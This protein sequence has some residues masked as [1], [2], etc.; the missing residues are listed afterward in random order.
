MSIAPDKLRWLEG[1]I[2]KDN[3]KKFYDSALWKHKRN[4]IRQRDNYE[5]QECKRKG[6]YSRAQN[7]HHLKEVKDRPDLALTDDNLEC[8][9]IRCHNAV[10]DKRLKNDKRKPFVNVERW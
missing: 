6:K 10:H 1:L 5:C 9:C 7:V 4:E 3:L 2:K 8:V